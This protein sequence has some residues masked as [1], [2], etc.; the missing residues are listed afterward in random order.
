M[1]RRLQ[2]A[3]LP[4]LPSLRRRP[5]PFAGMTSR[6]RP[7][8]TA[9]AT[10]G[11]TPADTAKE[12]PV[13]APVAASPAASA[14][15]AGV[16]GLRVNYAKA[17][18]SDAEAAAAPSPTAL[19]CEWLA[20]AVAAGEPEPNA[21]C[22]ST[23][24]EGGRP[25]ARF[26]LLKGVDERGFVWYTNY[27]S[28]KSRELEG[29]AAA[30]LTFWW[31]GSERSVR[32]EGDAARV[33]AAESDAYFASRPALSR[34]GAWASDQSAEVSGRGELEARWE[35]LVDEYLPGGEGGPAA[36]EIARPEHWGGFRL[37]P[38]RVEFWK[39]RS[40]RLHDRV[41]FERDGAGA[42]WTQK[43]LQP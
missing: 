41:V 9:T 17:G 31:A 22:L 4:A 43:R 6:A 32:V 14:A 20:D 42:A 2:P 5:H 12:A 1:L 25:A 34:L 27:G 40:S 19:F 23:V 38:T 10:A 7:A 16:A 39:G 30:A 36:K 21:M 11:G 33:A 13:A 35:A 18:L 24:G 29:N 28:R 3:F 37:V 15:A 26:V 8:P